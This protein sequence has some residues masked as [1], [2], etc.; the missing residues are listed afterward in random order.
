MNEQT[1][2]LGIVAKVRTRVVK[3]DGEPPEGADPI[4]HPQCREVLELEHGHAPVVIYKRT[5]E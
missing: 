1:I 3:W 5:E 4:G 2:P